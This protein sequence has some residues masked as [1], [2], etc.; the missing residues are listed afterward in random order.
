MSAFSSSSLWR[1]LAVLAS[2]PALLLMRAA[3]PTAAANSGGED[4]HSKHLYDA[5]MLV[6]SVDQAPHF[7]MFFAPWCGHCQK[8]QSTWNTLGD[9][10][11]EMP[12]P[13]AYVA[14]VDCTMHAQTCSDHGVKGYPTLKLF[15]PGQKSILYQGQR[16]LDTL[17]SWM[18]QTLNED[19][20]VQE[21]SERPS[22]DIPEP[23]HGLY[24][25]TSGSFKEHV[26]EGYH[27]IKF[28]APWCGHCKALIPTWEQLA[29]T[30]EYSGKVKIAKVDCTAHQDICN[31]NQVRGYPTLLWFKDGEK[32]DQYR[33][34][35]DLDSLKVF[36]DT[37]I[38]IE[39]QDE[40]VLQQAE[41]EEETSS[42]LVL[43]EN[44]F[45]ATVADGITFVKFYAPWCGHCKNL[46]P[47]WED[48]AKKEFSGLSKV[49]IAKVDCTSEAQLCS[50]QH[51]RGY[52]TL[53]L[54]VGGKQVGEHE[55]ARSLEAL[56]SYVLSRAR[57]EL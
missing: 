34:K 14:K 35:R 15:K 38:Q 21:E 20:G 49:T 9:K 47:T 55:G 13:P 1:R 3:Q 28:F 16:D 17:E 5:E 25:L 24:E 18:L 41:D 36:V 29:S 57:D 31:E 26:A 52:P 51:V 27:F 11:N 43:N 10:Y 32:V 40:V 8:L 37:Q 33:G 23:Q 45:D 6:H 46:A 48:L 30:F 56:H 50:K 54:Y 44:N 4:E 39:P 7:I 19:A 22:P 2:L 53:L 12:E 42:V